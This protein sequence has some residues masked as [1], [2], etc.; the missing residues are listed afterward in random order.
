MGKRTKYQTF[1]TCQLVVQVFDKKENDETKKD[2]SKQEDANE[3]EEN[4]DSD[5]NKQKFLGSLSAEDKA[6]IAEENADKVDVNSVINE[7]KI[8][9]AP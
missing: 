4:K 9:F 8:T 6:I 1:N 3:I 2:K 5:D 7:M